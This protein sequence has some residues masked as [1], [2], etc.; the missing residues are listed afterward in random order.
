MPLR[1]ACLRKILPNRLF[2]NKL[3]LRDA[4]VERISTLQLTKQPV[5]IGTESVIESE[6][7][8]NALQVAGIAHNVLNAKNDINE[9]ELIAMAGHAGAVT[10]TT[11]MAGRGT[12]IKIDA[13]VN[14][15][16]GLHVISCQANASRRIDRQ[17]IGRSARQ[18]D[19]G[20]AETWISL[21][22]SLLLRRLPLWQR[23]LCKKNPSSV[24][25]I[26]IKAMIVVSQAKEERYQS[27][28][29]K[30]LL[31]ADAALEDNFSFGGMH[32]D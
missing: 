18:G 12:D 16:G 3:E 8:S 7:L 23:N 13:Q 9:A 32:H 28:L 31:E 14:A 1:S 17:L 30:R 10:I 15:L 20:S 5:L 4:L 6:L 11:N 21:N 19:N 24:P 25:S 22:S 27:L 29:R 26:I 2:R